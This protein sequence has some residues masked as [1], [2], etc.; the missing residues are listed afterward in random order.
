VATI[1]GSNAWAVGMT[2]PSTCNPECKTL[3][4]HW[5]GTAWSPVPSPNPSAGYLND[6]FSVVAICPHNAW[7]VGTTDYAQTLIT[8]WNGKTWS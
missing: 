7:A 8:H 1:S 6:L 2:L 5:N 3:I 4:L